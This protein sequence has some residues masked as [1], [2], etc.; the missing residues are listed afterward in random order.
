MEEHLKA[1]MNLEKVH[2]FEKAAFDNQKFTF[3]PSTEMA[4]ALPF[5]IQYYAKKPNGERGRN[6]SKYKHNVFMSFCPFCG[7]P[8]P[9]QKGV[10]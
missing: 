6:L 7:A 1:Q 4:I 8:I 9:Q 5:T 10:Y 3:G 2:S